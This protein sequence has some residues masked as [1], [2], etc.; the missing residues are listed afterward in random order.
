MVS[1]KQNIRN[2]KIVTLIFVE[3]DADELI[4]SRLLDH[5]REK[6]W[7]QQGDVKVVNTSGFPSESK[8]KSK[9]TQIKQRYGKTQIIFNAVFCEYDT[10]IFEKGIQERPNWKKIEDNLKRQYDVAHFGRIEAKTSIEDWM[11][12]DL[13]GLLAA[14]G[15][16]KDTKPK[17]AT[18]Q[19][20][21]KNLSLKKSMVYDRHKGKLKIKPIIDKLDIG[22][23]RKARKKELGEFERV[24]GIKIVAPKAR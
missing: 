8:M 1:R 11:L 17:G 15:L 3:G 9:L 19:D 20:K 21:V 16:P 5:Y 2:K 23:I 22:K 13:D 14:L 12:D 18:G 24:L 10:D 6:G 7:C 4:I